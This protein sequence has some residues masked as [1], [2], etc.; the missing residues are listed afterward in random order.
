MVIQLIIEH[1]AGTPSLMEFRVN[2]D[3]PEPR[4]F[5]KVDTLT[6]TPEADPFF[7]GPPEFAT[8]SW[9]WDAWWDEHMI[10]MGV[11]IIVDESTDS[12]IDILVYQEQER[13]NY[14]KGFQAPTARL[15]TYIDDFDT[16]DDYIFIDDGRGYVT[17]MSDE[18]DIPMLSDVIEPSLG[19]FGYDFEYEPFFQ[20][21]N[22]L[23]IYFDL[24]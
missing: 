15:Y 24:S 21:N 19:D 14:L 17:I 18:N 5:D 20:L 2:R 1:M 10:S 11:P 13:A 12:E 23:D 6:G 4:W 3:I 22:W 7:V 8:Q 9:E 16:L